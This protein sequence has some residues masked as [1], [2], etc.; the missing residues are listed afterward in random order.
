MSRYEVRWLDADKDLVRLVAR[1]LAEGDA[2]SSE[3]RAVVGVKVGAS[4]VGGIL[5]ALRRSPL[6]GAS[7]RLERKVTHGRRVEL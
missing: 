3:L 4:Q 5:A 7:L 2:A 6:V 1:R